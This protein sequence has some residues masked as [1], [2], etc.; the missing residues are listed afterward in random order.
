VETGHVRDVFTAPRHKYT[1]QLLTYS[2]LGR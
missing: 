2:E 1:Q